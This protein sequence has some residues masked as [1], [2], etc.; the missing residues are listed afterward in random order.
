MPAGCDLYRY[1]LFSP[2][3]PAPDYAQVMAGESS[4]WRDLYQAALL[5]LDEAALAAKIQAAY[6]AIRERMERLRGNGERNSE[7]QALNDAAQTLRTLEQTE[8]RRKAQRQASIS[9]RR[10]I[11][12]GEQA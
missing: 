11:S 8:S 5:E 9:Q 6:G 7:W 3:F 10:E 2:F 1:L 12:R 4:A